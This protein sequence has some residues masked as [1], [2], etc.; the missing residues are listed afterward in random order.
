MPVPPRVALDDEIDREELFEE[1]ILSIERKE[2][3]ER[4]AKRKQGMADF[5]RLLEASGRVSV[6]AQWRRASC[7]TQLR[8]CGAA[9]GAP[10]SHQWQ[11]RSAA[12]SRGL[13]SC[14]FAT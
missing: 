5:K 8:W 4:R 14:T 2:A 13:S 3:G 1:Y 9:S 7:P 10:H 11:R 12:G 6:S